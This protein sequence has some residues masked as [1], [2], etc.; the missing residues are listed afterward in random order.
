MPAPVRVTDPAGVTVAGPETT[1]YM[2]LPGEFDTACTMNGGSPYVCPSSGL[3]LL[4]LVAVLTGISK[5]KSVL[6]GM[7]EELE[8]L[9]GVLRTTSLKIQ[10]SCLLESCEFANRLVVSPII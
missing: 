4:S 7:M 10:R 1:E 3:N 5:C 6:T 9:S 2:I 8:M